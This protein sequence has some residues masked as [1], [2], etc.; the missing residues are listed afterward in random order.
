MTLTLI[1]TMKNTWH[2]FLAGICM[3][4]AITPNPA[5]DEKPEVEETA[6]L[7]DDDTE[8]GNRLREGSSS[9]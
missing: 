7:F 6:D 4:V 8:R 1:L 2:T 9:I 5:Y 3:S